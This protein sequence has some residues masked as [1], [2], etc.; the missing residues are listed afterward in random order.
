MKQLTDLQAKSYVWS[1][2]QMYMQI[3]A[4]DFCRCVY[5]L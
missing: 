5:V 3:D 4:V 2:L 1:I